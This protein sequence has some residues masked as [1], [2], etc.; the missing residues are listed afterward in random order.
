MQQQP[1]AEHFADPSKM[2][3]QQQPA[4]LASILMSICRLLDCTMY[5]CNYKGGS[6]DLGPG[7]ASSK[8]PLHVMCARYV[9]WTYVLNHLLLISGP[10]VRDHQF[11]RISA[12]AEMLW[13]AVIHHALEVR[14][15]YTTPYHSITRYPSLHHPLYLNT[16][17]PI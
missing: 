2:R 11:P 13:P 1:A 9:L 16:K 15:H 3:Y 17:H 5:I 7:E 8:V 10:S 12:S 4:L 6:W 14:N